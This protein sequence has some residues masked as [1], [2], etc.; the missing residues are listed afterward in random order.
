MK[1][2]T[3]SNCYNS[4]NFI[5]FL[6]YVLHLFILYLINVKDINNIIYT[7]GQILLFNFVYLFFFGLFGYIPLYRCINYSDT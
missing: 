7:I 5:A 3:M 2:A 4:F 6:D 1:I